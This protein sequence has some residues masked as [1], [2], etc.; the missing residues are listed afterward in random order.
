MPCIFASIVAKSIYD[1]NGNDDDNDD[2]N[3]NDDN[4]DW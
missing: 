1:G 4:D 2:G 3:N